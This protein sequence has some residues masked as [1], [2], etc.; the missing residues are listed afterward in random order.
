MEPPVIVFFIP[1]HEVPETVGIFNRLGV[2][3]GDGKLL[4]RHIPQVGVCGEVRIPF[5]E[6]E[7]RIRAAPRRVL[8]LRFR[9]QRHLFP[10]FPGKPAAEF[11]GP[12]PRHPD[13]RKTR[14]GVHVVAGP[15]LVLVVHVVPS[16]EVF[17]VKAA[18]L[19]QRHFRLS[20]PE[21]LF[22][23]H[24][25][26]GFF[27]RGFPFTSHPE[28]S[29]GNA[30]ERH[31][32][33]TPQIHGQRFIP[34]FRD[35]H[36]FFPDAGDRL[37]AVNDDAAG[38]SPE[39]GVLHRHVIP[40]RSGELPVQVI[41]AFQQ[42]FIALSRPFAQVGGVHVHP[43]DQAVPVLLRHL[44]A[45][46]PLFKELVK[47][48]RIREELRGG[49]PQVVPLRTVAAHVGVQVPV[50]DGPGSGRTLDGLQCHEVRDSRAGLVFR[51]VAADAVAVQHGL[52]F[53]HEGEGARRTVPRG[54]G[55]RVL[56]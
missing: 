10:G 34:R 3:A 2:H 29:R 53:I 28:F 49:Q 36:A 11:H 14:I 55:G 41:A 19:L 42:S 54:D 44:H 5:P 18:V 40:F 33:A 16:I 31:A 47:F 26:G 51:G 46:V 56:P 37:A 39:Q 24:R 22:N 7:V 8:P 25:G 13:G 21:R 35:G 30:A 15:H 32:Y 20:H 12:G 9:G 48:R 27:R 43:R 52:H 4:Q 6:E 45:V 50:R 23:L 1:R 17:R 38:V